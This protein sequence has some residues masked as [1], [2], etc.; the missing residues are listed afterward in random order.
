MHLT[1]HLF[2]S[3]ES[4][5]VLLPSVPTCSGARL[6]RVWSCKVSRALAV[7][8]LSALLGLLDDL[9]LSHFLD[10]LT[11][12]VKNTLALSSNVCE[13]SMICVVSS[14]IGLVVSSTSDCSY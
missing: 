11:G 4:D 1:L 14:S 8:P 7:V 9:A 13:C 12:L 10:L 2:V 3:V 6:F 5:G